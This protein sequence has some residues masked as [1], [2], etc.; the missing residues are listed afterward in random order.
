MA[1][2]ELPLRPDLDD[3]QFETELEG[4]T[5]QFRVAWNPR[6]G[7]YFLSLLD[8]DENEL[9]PGVRVVLGVPLYIRDTDARF[10][11]G[12]LIAIDTSHTDVEPAFG[13][14]GRRVKLLYVEAAE[15]V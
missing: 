7:A 12:Q 5:Y 14:F 4:E 11:P 3:Y 10:P 2:L 8:G 6:A 9:K 15:L 1:T 13:E